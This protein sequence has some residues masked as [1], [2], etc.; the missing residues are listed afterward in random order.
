MYGDCP[1]SPEG[2]LAV[3]VGVDLLP[4]LVAVHDR[5]L[6]LELVLPDPDCHKNIED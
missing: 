2:Q 1:S 6:V 3:H 4:N 5:C